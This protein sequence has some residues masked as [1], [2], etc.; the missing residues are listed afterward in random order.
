MVIFIVAALFAGFTS[1]IN[2]FEAPV[3]TFQ[4]KYGMSRRR[5]PWWTLWEWR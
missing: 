1:L 2:L 3:A 5:W 4:E